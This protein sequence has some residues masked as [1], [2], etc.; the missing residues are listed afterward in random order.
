M[1]KEKNEQQSNE[2]IEETLENHSE[3]AESSEYNESTE[4]ETATETRSTIVT[5]DNNF[6]SFF[7]KLDKKVVI[8][9]A[10][11]LLI[12]LIGGASLSGGHSRHN[13]ADGRPEHRR[14]DGN[15]RGQQEQKSWKQ[16]RNEDNSKSNRHNR[17]STQ[18]GDTPM[19]DNS[20]KDETK[21][22]EDSKNR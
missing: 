10:S 19:K 8:Y 17:R 21:S 14:F 6:K 4:Q 20:S 7:K 13:F 15:R 16:E 12:G 1:D 18:Q 3:K 11:F 5:E 22:S 2:S 9:S